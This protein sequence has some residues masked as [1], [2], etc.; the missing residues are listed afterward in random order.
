LYALSER[1]IYRNNPGVLQIL[2]ALTQVGNAI[3][4]TFVIPIL[5]I[6]TCVFYFDLRV[7]KEAFDLQ[8]LMDPT[9][10]RATPPG[11]GSVPSIL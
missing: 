11:T 1:V 2:A 9:S 6:A 5:L 3:I 10:E 4:N 7:R 8:F